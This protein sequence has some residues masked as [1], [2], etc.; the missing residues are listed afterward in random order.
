MVRIEGGIMAPLGSSASV[1]DGIGNTPVVKLRRLAP[2][3]GAEVFVKLEYIS[4]TGSYKD[5]LA[6]AMITGAER[7]GVLQP[8][9]RVVEYTGGSTASSLGMVCAVKGYPFM[10]V[11]SDAFLRR[12][13]RQRVAG[14]AK[15]HGF[16]RAATGF[17][18]FAITRERE[19]AERLAFSF[20]EAA[21]QPPHISV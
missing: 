16:S 2:P 11:T 5:R 21:L 13:A 9:M 7:R 6:L 8:G 18:S 17:F 4:P 1:L 15:G 20:P 14:L 3:S 19:G 10:A 12:E